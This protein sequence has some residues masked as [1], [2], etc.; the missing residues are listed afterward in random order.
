MKLNAT[1]MVFIAPTRKRKDSLSCSKIS[2]PMTAAWPEPIPGRKE[3]R[4]ADIRAATDVL[5]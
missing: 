5:M 1:T 2:E 3:Q 4:G